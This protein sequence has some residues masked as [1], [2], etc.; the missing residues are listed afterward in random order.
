MVAFKDRVLDAVA[1]GQ[2]PGNPFEAAR[3]GVVEQEVIVARAGIGI[4]VGERVDHRQVTQERIHVQDRFDGRREILGRSIVHAVNDVHQ[5]DHIAVIGLRFIV[6]FAIRDQAILCRIAADIRAVIDQVHRTAH[7]MAG[8]VQVA[9]IVFGA[10]AVGEKFPVNA[11]DH[12]VDA[13]EDRRLVVVVPI[14][15]Q[16]HKADE[17]GRHTREAHRVVR[18][19]L[20]DHGRVADVVQEHQ[21]PQIVEFLPV[22]VIV[23]VYLPGFLLARHTQGKLSAH[24]KADVFQALAKDDC[25][26]R[27]GGLGFDVQPERVPIGG[28]Q[29]DVHAA[30]LAVVEDRPIVHTAGGGIAHFDGHAV[31]GGVALRVGHFERDEI[32]ARFFV[33]VAGVPAFRGGV[34]IVTAIGIQIPLVLDNAPRA[35]STPK[36]AEINRQRRP[37]LGRHGERVGLDDRAGGDR[38]H[39]IDALRRVE[40][41]QRG[42]GQEK[43]KNQRDFKEA[44]GL[45]RARPD[46]HRG[47][48]CHTTNPARNKGRIGAMPDGSPSEL[49]VMAL[50]P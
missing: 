17:T 46:N 12:G 43:N 8:L 25:I 42:R 4:P 47:L 26:R 3:P 9:G 5:A 22:H 44:I 37:A 29:R 10:E 13:P 16:F 49:K 35:G 2:V 7:G 39:P 24:P 41:H 27:D 40:D 23:S 14:N 36:R 45:A 28:G 21:L 15:P 18:Q 1:P 30:H 34:G 20:L 50:P 32:I 19:F 48:F 31:G 11:F 38:F 33:D 6:L